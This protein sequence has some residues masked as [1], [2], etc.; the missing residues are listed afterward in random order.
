MQ[1]V[2][3]SDKFQIAVPAAVR[4][5]LGIKR[6]DRLLVHVRGNHIL[7]MPEPDSYADRLAGLHAEIWSGVDPAEYVRHERE[8]WRT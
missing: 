2:K 7:L 1:T 3:V 5:Q 8:E 6:G 4:R